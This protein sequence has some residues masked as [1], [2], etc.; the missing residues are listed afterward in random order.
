MSYY[1]LILN[2]IFLKIGH[3][4]NNYLYDPKMDQSVL[5]RSKAADEMENSGDP[6]QTAP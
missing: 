2:A 3:L 5:Q 1:Y 4:R 6:E